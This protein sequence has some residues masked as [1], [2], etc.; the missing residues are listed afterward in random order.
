MPYVSGAVGILLVAGAAVIALVI[1][2]LRPRRHPGPRL[3]GDDGIDRD[4][5]EAAEREV[6]ELE[7]G[8][9]PEDGFEGDDWG[10]GASRPRPPVRL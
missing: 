8:Q 5:L 4:E 7:S 3:V 9:R 6:R 1:W 2:L 10:P